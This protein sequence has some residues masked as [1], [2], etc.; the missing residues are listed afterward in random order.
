MC[1]NT[2]NFI[3]QAIIQAFP[4]NHFDLHQK[5][6][7]SD[8]LHGNE[9]FV[10]GPCQ[11]PPRFLNAL[12][13][14]DLVASILLDLSEIDSVTQRELVPRLEYMINRKV[15][16][17][18]NCWLIAIITSI[19]ER[20]C[21][22]FQGQGFQTS[23]EQA[24]T[25]LHQ[26]ERSASEAS[27]AVNSENLANETETTHPFNPENLSPRPVTDDWQRMY[28]WRRQIYAD[29]LYACDNGFQIDDLVIRLD[30]TRM[31]EQ[32][33]CYSKAAPLPP[34]LPEE[35]KNTQFSVI[36]DDTF[37]VLIKHR[38]NGHNPVGVNFANAYQPGGG[39]EQGCPAQEEALCR[40]SNHILGLKKDPR[41]YQP[42]LPE[43]GGVYCPHVS[44]F[45]EDEAHDYA[46]MQDPVEVALIAVAAYDLRHSS[47]DRARLRMASN[48]SEE[49]W[50]TNETYLNGMKHKIRNMLRIMASHGHTHLVLGALGCG[51]F[52]NSPIIVSR[53]FSEIFS[54]EEFQGRFEVV[55]F[56]I[57]V[58]REK[59]RE[60]IP[61]F[62]EICEQLNNGS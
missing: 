52:A 40:R 28:A 25:L 54:E 57:L 30:H 17:S 60:N 12:S 3:D 22:F 39:V 14:D 7:R 16:K 61:C 13:M 56:A 1:F 49:N 31:K 38:K 8:R 44:V 37:N 10:V 26:L 20:V 36:Q 34:L 18:N 55:D 50:N 27:Q 11:S 4:S 43:F 21:R 5:V 47:R 42:S 53:L 9:A 51:A 62:Q 29:T 15:Q 2:I 58:A 48:I 46:F 32:T 59:D 23:L 35:K 45:R 41:W 6:Y 33:I 24:Q 19:F